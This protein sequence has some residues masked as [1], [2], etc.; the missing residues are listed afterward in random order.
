MSMRIRIP[1]I[2]EK[3]PVMYFLLQRF[4]PII[5]T[6]QPPQTR[7]RHQQFLSTDALVRNGREKRGRSGA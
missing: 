7:H 5:E 2:F 1:T 6:T 3:N 4:A